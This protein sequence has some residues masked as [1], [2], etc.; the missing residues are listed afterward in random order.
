[1]G[2]FLGKS[3]ARVLDGAA[4]FV[5][6]PGG[7]LREAVELLASGALDFVGEGGRSGL[8]GFGEEGARAVERLA[9]DLF[10]LRL[11]MAYEVAAGVVE[12]AGKDARD[13]AGFL[14][15]GLAGL[16]DGP[17]REAL[18]LRLCLFLVPLGGFKDIFD[19]L[20]AKLGELGFELGEIARG[21]RL[22][23]FLEKLL[24]AAKI[25]AETAERFGES[26]VGAGADAVLL[27]SERG[28]E[29]RAAT[30]EAVKGFFRARDVRL[31]HRFD[32]RVEFRERGAARFLKRGENARVD[33][34]KK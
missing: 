29:Q 4:C 31:N 32:L 15:Q 23:R 34:F 1:S 9:D 12:F 26:F 21:H 10:E 6:G 27:E 3:G 25:F 24:D 20:L 7:F 11:R 17:F 2:R 16:V 19:G 13:F 8:R 28:I 14:A 22:S 30:G 18:N 5:R 33:F